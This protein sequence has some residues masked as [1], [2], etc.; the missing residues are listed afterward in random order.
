VSFVEH[1]HSHGYAIVNTVLSLDDVDQ[2]IGILNGCN[3]NGGRRGGIRNLLEIDAMR[4][5]AQSPPVLALIHPVLGQE[6]FPVRGI[7]FDKQD[8]TNWKVPWHQDVTIA[9]KNR[10]EADGYGPWSI[11]DGVLHVQP[12]SAILEKMVSVRLHLDD[13][14]LANGALRVIPGSHRHGRVDQNCI[15]DFVLKHAEVVCEVNRGDALLMRPLTIHASSAA[16]IPSHRRVIHFDFANVELAA[17]L[18]W[19]E[20]QLSAQ[21]T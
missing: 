17:G 14:P 21:I 1:L 8:G 18:A 10:I 19:H 9:V 7:L 3:S 13:C 12:P 5:L 6:A 2:Y 15:S 20:C 11:K 16:S 4:E